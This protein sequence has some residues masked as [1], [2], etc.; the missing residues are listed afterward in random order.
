LLRS[1]SQEA[2]DRQTTKND[3]IPRHMLFPLFGSG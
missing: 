2:S 3:R 1:N